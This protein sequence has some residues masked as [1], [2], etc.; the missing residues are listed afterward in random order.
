M[1]CRPVVWRYCACVQSSMYP[2]HTGYILGV[3]SV[4]RRV[5]PVYSAVPIMYSP[6]LALA[7]GRSGHAKYGIPLKAHD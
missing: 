4:L 3:Q 6:A 7:Q 1:E 2:V 5:H